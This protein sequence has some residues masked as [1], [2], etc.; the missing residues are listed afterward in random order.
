MII[1]LVNGGEMMADVTHTFNDKN[2]GPTL[3]N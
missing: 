1:A 2:P 3:L